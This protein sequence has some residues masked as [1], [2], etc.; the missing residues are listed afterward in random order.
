MAGI[1]YF[2]GKNSN[3]SPSFVVWN[4]TT[5]KFGECFEWLCLTGISHLIFAIACAFVFGKVSR[6]RVGP[7]RSVSKFG[8][9]RVA[10]CYMNAVCALI[11]VIVAYTFEK[12]HPPAFVLSKTITF[13]T[14]ILCALLYHK[15]TGV[16]KLAAITSKQILLPFLVVMVSSSIQLYDHL[17]NNVIV[18][19]KL[20]NWYT[21]SYL[22]LNVI[23]LLIIA[24]SLCLTRKSNLT[25]GRQLSSLISAGI[26]LPP[27]F[28]Y[29]RE[30]YCEEDA[31]LGTHIDS[32]DSCNVG[33][34][35]LVRES[36]LGWAEEEANFFSKIFFHWVNPLMKKG[37]KTLLR[38]AD[39]LFLLPLSLDTKMIK[40]IFQSVL[41]VQKLSSHSSFKRNLKN[42]NTKRCATLEHGNEII[43]K[44]LN[45]SLTKALFKAFGM[46]YMTVGILKFLADCLSFVGPILLNNLVSFIEKKQE[47]VEHGYYYAFGLMSST[48]VGALLNA[49]FTYQVN[50]VR[51]QCRAALVTT[52][53][54]KALSVSSTSLSG[55]STGQVINFMSTD[56][57]R[58]LNFCNSFHQ[59]W[60]LPFQ[61]AVSLY[62][63][64]QQV[65]I[66]FLSGLGFAVI[67]IPINRWIALKI[68]EFSRKMM[69]KKDQRVKLISECLFG[70]RMVKFCAWE[71]HFLKTIEKIRAGELN[72]L[73]GR[74]Y[75]DALCVYFW[76][77]TPVLI[78]ILTFVTYILLGNKLT[79]AK[80]FT[81][82]A[83]FNILIAPLN[84]FPWVINGLMEAWVSIKRIEKFMTLQE[85]NFEDYYSSLTEGVLDESDGSVLEVDSGLFRWKGWKPDRTMSEEEPVNQE[86]DVIKQPFLLENIHLQIRKGDL[87]GVIGKVGSGKSSLLAAITAEMERLDGKVYTSDEIDGFGFVNQDPWIQHMTIR[88]N[89]LFGKPFYQRFY[90]DVIEACALREDLDALPD[91]DLT[92]VGEHGHTLSGG[93]KARISLARAVYQN[94]CIY[95]MDDPFAAV[96]AHVS[97]HILSKCMLG[98]LK[99][100]TRI[101]CTHHTKYLY[102]ADLII[103]VD[104]GSIVM[105]GTP[106]EILNSSEIRQLSLETE[107]ETHHKDTDKDLYQRESSP[108]K[109]SKESF[110][111]GKLVDEEE[112]ETGS[113]AFNVYKSYWR[114]VGHILSVAVIIFLLLMQA[115]RNISDW[116]L[117]Y[118]ISEEKEKLNTSSSQVHVEDDTRF[119]II[120]YGALAGANTVFTLFRAFL[121]AYGGVKAAKVVHKK[122]LTSILKAPIVFFDTTPI[123]R[124]VN[125]FSTDVYSV[126]D[127]LPFMLNIFLAQAFGVFGTIAITCYGIPW[128][129][130][131]LVP[132]GAVYVYT[133][134]YYRKTS[135]ELK[136]I[137]SISLS[138]IYEHFAETLSG[139]STIRA[140]RDVARFTEDNETKLDA[141]QRAT[142]SGF[143]ASQWLMLRLQLIGVVMVTMV[144][145]LAV[146]EHHISSVDPGLVGL[147]IAYAL[148]I[149]D[150]LSGL[151]TSFTETEMQ[152]VSVE[153][154]H[155]YIDGAPKEEEFPQTK[156]LMTVDDSWPQSGAILFK[157][158]TLV[159][160]PDLPPALKNLN[161]QI[162]SGEKIGICGRTGSGKSSLFSVL[163]RMVPL[164][165]GAIRIDGVNAINIPLKVLRSKI[166]IIPQDPFLFDGSIR[167]NIDPLEKHT[168][169]EITYML[170]KCHVLDLVTNMGGLDG[171]VGERGQ[172]LSVGQK[173]LFTLARALLR[174]SKIICIDEATANVDLETDKLIQQT[175]KTELKNSTVLTI[176]HR[177]DTILESDRV[178][179]MSKGIVVEFDDPAVLM[180]NTKSMF[181]SLVNGISK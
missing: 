100:K 166:A 49:Q 146:I 156:H 118:W 104:K 138:P 11:G 8:M 124:I 125:R 14:W 45:V 113:V 145:F 10:V 46:F 88:E 2:C 106:D 41:R 115:S 44:P 55:F 47:P 78:S 172:N 158:V 110:K 136:R 39:D 26:Q 94:K 165:S 159:Y 31:L 75:L 170:E 177:M 103:V 83:L 64:Y 105:S 133:Q 147:A 112:R 19:K 150:R 50:K 153:R 23:F 171:S 61:I 1:K 101:I 90:Q 36:V 174:N 114:A 97:Q 169:S 127:S 144:S 141:S 77:T 76:A 157:D 82:I 66:A 85:L 95:L 128:F 142:F 89:I 126:D 154:A 9:F 33:S 40:E 43:R 54:E 160:R 167:D 132:L 29:N 72:C 21:V 130:A 121:F 22:T 3:S 28:D 155:Q 129:A 98:M 180:L 102:D 18:F 80:V 67:L 92:E 96:D 173:Q 56:T 32:Y 122:L 175:I 178:I 148:S 168:D 37:D 79:A 109:K 53:Y 62:L 107:D 27:D 60:S 73:K 161:L 65:G 59:F 71:D 24:I 15:L 139:L 20:A 131:V 87:I 52:V 99:K 4:S 181:Y 63:L 7:T 108:P 68:M 84:A 34:P 164:E 93:Q 69:D 48:L 137:V 35:S 143:V 163:F 134:N 13:S 117:A 151:V 6:K 70:I 123:G 140:L 17:E 176:S 38:R 74:K 119:Y 12:H 152:M 116:W 120:V 42:R 86:Y 30:G 149:T 25:L 58:I 57:D 162:R 111:S 179:V 5:N 16:R 135:R 51:L 91:G 81:S